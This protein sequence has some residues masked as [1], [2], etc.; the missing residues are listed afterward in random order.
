MRLPKTDNDRVDGIKFN[1]AMEQIEDKFQE[2]E[3][4]LRKVS[5]KPPSK[6]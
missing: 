2:L 6:E 5:P 3:N 1:R 4:K